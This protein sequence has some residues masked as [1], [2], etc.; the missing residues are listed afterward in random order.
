MGT[1]LL[2]LGVTRHARCWRCLVI[3]GTSGAELSAPF[4]TWRGAFVTRRNGCVL[5]LTSA[6]LARTPRAH[7]VTRGVGALAF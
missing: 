4:V 2:R 5:V 3:F 6:G 1:D 7:F